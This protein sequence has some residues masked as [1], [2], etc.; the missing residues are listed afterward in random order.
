MRLLV[1]LAL[2]NGCASLPHA[3]PRDVE[4]ARQRW[5][6]VSLAQL[7]EGRDTYVRRCAGCH[8]LVLP[9]KLA[10]DAWPK[11]VAKMGERAKIDEAE[12][13]QILRFVM[14]LAER[15]PSSP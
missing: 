13:Q 1:G 10:P 5:P 15:P 14:T 9:Q 11:A 3:E 7:E 6:E 2:L 8:S 12:R 4:V